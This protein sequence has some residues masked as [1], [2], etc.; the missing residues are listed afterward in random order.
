MDHR[1]YQAP[2][3]SRLP[4]PHLTT[5]ARFEWTRRP[6]TGPGTAILGHLAGATVVELGCGSGH[7]LA[8]L[9]SHHGASGTGVDHDPA[10]IGRARAG[11]GH[12]T[13]IRFVR[14][15]ACDFLNAAAPGS[16]DLVLSIF[17]AFSFTDPLPLLTATARILR[18]GGHLALTLRADDHHDTLDILRRRAI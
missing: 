6:G 18:P 17:G 3:R 12:L 16:A 1:D 5:P 9:V 8:H 13:G 2:D 4:A 11:Y 10:K 14:A 15:D 7:N